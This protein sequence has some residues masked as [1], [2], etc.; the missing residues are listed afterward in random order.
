ML[1]K[2]LGDGWYGQGTAGRRAPGGGGGQADRQTERE[3][4]RERKRGIE[5]ISETS[6]IQKAAI[7]YYSLG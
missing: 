1:I 2:V 6:D 3:R 5:R 7:V 4:E